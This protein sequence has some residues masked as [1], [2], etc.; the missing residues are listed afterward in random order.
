MLQTA[1]DAFGRLDVLVNNAGIETR[2]SSLDTTEADF[3]KVIAVTW[4]TPSPPA[5][6]P[7]R[8]ARSAHGSLRRRG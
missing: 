4:P 8:L 1:V 5:S 2:Q 3:E 7:K 6:P